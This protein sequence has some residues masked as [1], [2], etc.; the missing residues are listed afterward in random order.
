MNTLATIKMP[1][2]ERDKNYLAKSIIWWG[3][4]LILE[5]Q[6]YKMQD[7]PIKEIMLKFALWSPVPAYITWVHQMN[8]EKIFK[9]FIV[10][11][12]GKIFSATYFV[13]LPILFTYQF[14]QRRR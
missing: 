9:S 3:G 11:N 2:L 10:S 14:I 1:L 6:E 7:K 12:K 4:L 5:D 8:P 13:G